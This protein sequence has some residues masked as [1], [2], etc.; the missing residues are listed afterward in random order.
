MVEVLNGF[1]AR[2]ALC[3][4]VGC[5]LTVLDEPIEGA[6]EFERIPDARCRLTSGRTVC[7]RMVSNGSKED[8][9][10]LQQLPFIRSP[11]QRVRATARA[12]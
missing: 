7:K 2:D 6:G 8:I 5:V 12:R 4:L 9:A 3:L 11:R 1:T 10:A